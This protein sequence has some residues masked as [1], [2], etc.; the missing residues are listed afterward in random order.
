MKTLVKIY[1][2]DYGETATLDDEMYKVA[3]GE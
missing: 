1:Y 3:A 2:P